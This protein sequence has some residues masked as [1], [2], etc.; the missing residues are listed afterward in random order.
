MLGSITEHH[1]PAYCMMSIGFSYSEPALCHAT[2]SLLFR[3]YDGRILIESGVEVNVCPLGYA[4]ERHIDVQP[5]PILKTV[6][7]TIPVLS[8]SAMRRISYGVTLAGKS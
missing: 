8:V 6:H 4:P 7:V 2:V 1:S 3:D 5:V